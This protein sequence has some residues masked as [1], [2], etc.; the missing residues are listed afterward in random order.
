MLYSLNG[1]PFSFLSSTDKSSIPVVRTNPLAIYGNNLVYWYDFTD[2]STLFNTTAATTNVSGY[3]DT[4]KAIRSKSNYSQLLTSTTTQANSS[5]IYTSLTRFNGYGGILKTNSAITESFFERFLVT[6]VTANTLFG[7]HIAFSYPPN[8]ATNNAQLFYFGTALRVGNVFHF[9]KDFANKLLLT[10]TGN[11][12][13]AFR[14]ISFNG[15]YMIFSFLI[16]PNVSANSGYT[17]LPINN[18]RN[19]LNNNYVGNINYNYEA[20]KSFIT[21]NGN[22]RLT[23][24]GALQRNFYMQEFILYQKDDNDARF[25]AGHQYL[26]QKYLS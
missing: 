24:F 15:S 7:A 9:N 14:I 10:N 2:T 12:G 21:Q 26:R 13:P 5:F 1:N 4:I 19:I 8:L 16:N 23:L 18:F 17:S 6:A 20:G 3:G 25:Q 22:L 11:E